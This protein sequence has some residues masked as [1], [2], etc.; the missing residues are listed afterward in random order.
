MARPRL[1]LTTAAL[2][3]LLIGGGAMAQPDPVSAR[4]DGLRRMQANLEAIGAV[5]NS[6]GNTRDTVARADEMVAFFRDLPSLFPP[7]S[8]GNGSKALPAVWSDR[9]GFERAAANATTAAE[10]LRNTAAGGDAGATGQAVRAMGG[11]CGA[12]HRNNRSR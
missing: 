3:A 1:L 9:P 8:D 10:A 2:A 4:K 11:A 12:C 6:G 5:A 7:G